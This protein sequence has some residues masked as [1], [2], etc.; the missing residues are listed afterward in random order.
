MGRDLLYSLRVLRRSPRFTATAMLVLALGTGANTAMFCLVNSVL[1]RPLPYHDPG[2]IGVLLASSETRAGAFSMPPADFLDFRARNRSFT[3]MA[4]AELWSP[5]LTGDSEPEQLQ[6]L[7]ASASLF[8]V[9]GVP[10]VIGRAFRLEDERAGAAPVVVLGAGVWKRRFG[11]DRSIVGRAITLN[12]AS[13]T[14]IGVLPEGFYFPPFW[15]SDAEIYT[16]LLWTP[17]KAQSRD[18]STL[19]CFGRL[20]PGVT[21]S[22]ASVEMR[23]IAGQLAAEFPASNAGKSAVLTPLHDM[24]VGS[25][26]G[27]L[28]ILLAAVGCTLLIACANLANLFLAR[29]TGRAREMAIRQALGAARATLVRQLLTESLVVSLAG[30]A[31]GLAAAWTI[32]KAF[33]AALPASGN[34]RMP[35]AQEIAL[36]PAAIAFHLAICL[37]AALLFGLLPALRASRNNLSGAMKSASRAAT[38]DRAGLRI[39]GVLVVSEIALALVL[40]AGAALLLESFRKL[41]NLDAGFDPRNLVAVNVAVAGSG[42][43]QPDRRSAFFREAVDRLRSLPGVTSASAVNHVPLAGDTFRLGIAIEGRPAPRP[44]DDVNAIYRVA[45]PGYFHTMGMRFR[46]G[47]DFDA[48]DIEGSPLVAVVNQTMAR[49]YWPGEEAIG[50]RFRLRQEWIS[51]IGVIADPKQQVWSAPSDSEM[52]LP[53][54]QDA[55]YLHDPGS[56]LSMTLVVRTAGGASTVTAAIREQIARIDRNVPVTAILPMEQVISGAVWQARLSAAVFAAFAALALVLATTGIFAVMSYIVTGRTQEIGIRMALGARQGDVLLM[57]LLQSMKPVAAGI[58]IGLCG[59]FALTGLMKTLLYETSPTDPA[60]LAAVSL[61]LI[62]V[63]AVAGLLPARRASRI[64][65]LTALRDS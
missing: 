55:S 35:R 43:A 45:L 54:L 12:R 53:Y 16:P 11:G 31:V 41:H 48:R 56:F 64:D 59:A 49:R 7:R 33:L 14:V 50:K 60:L 37:A 6:G 52:Y 8:D 34:F 3:A 24:A 40:L 20:K 2:R 23:G 17:A 29:A 22:M 58:A 9:L 30:G 62:A 26:R 18:G 42:H 25:V 27:S 13:Y 61:L 63:A 19:R 65:P 1:L 51:V 10:A 32:V 44:S 15:A 28:R 4:A 57:V 36:D 39:R 21:W 46:R 5:S 47:R 38:A